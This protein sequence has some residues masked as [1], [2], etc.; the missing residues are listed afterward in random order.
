MNLER[1]LGRGFA[2]MHAD[3]QELE[4]KS[5]VAFLVNTKLQLSFW[6]I[7]ENLR[8]SASN[9]F[10]QDALKRHLTR[11][12]S[13]KNRIKTDFTSEESLLRLYPP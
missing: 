6:L 11:S 1:A 13:D 7:S 5:Q 10:F 12:E 9:S 3:I 4:S 2:L 8:S